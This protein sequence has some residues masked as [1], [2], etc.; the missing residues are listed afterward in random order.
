MLDMAKKKI[1]APVVRELKALRLRLDLSQEEFAKH[2]KIN[3][4]TLR[5][6][7]QGA[8]RPDASTAAFIRLFLDKN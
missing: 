2:L 8:A 1:I 7:E 6:W 3:V 5:K 4:W